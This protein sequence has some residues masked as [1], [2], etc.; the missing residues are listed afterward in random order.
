MRVYVPYYPSHAGHWIYRGYQKAWEHLGYDVKLIKAFHEKSE[1]GKLEYVTTNFHGLDAAPGDYIVQ[2]IGSLINGPGA[3]EAIQNSYKSFISVQPN[4]YPNPWGTH[5]NFQCHAPSEAIR[6]LNRTPNVHLWTFGDE[7][8]YHVRWKKVHTVPLAFDHISYQ[9]KEIERYKKFDVCFVGGWANNGFNEK[10]EIMLNTFKEFKKSNLN[11]GI[12]I[13]KNL[14]HEQEQG[15]LYNS[16]IALNIHDAYQRKLGH[17]TNE[18][19]F[20]SLGLNGILISDTVGQFNRIFS[21]MS[22]SNDPK[23]MVEMCNAVLSLSEKEREG[24]RAHN[25]N[26]IMERECYIHRVQQMLELPEVAPEPIGAD[27][28]IL[29]V[30]NEHQVEEINKLIENS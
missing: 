4:V 14:T 30:M 22:T 9:P 8:R 27:E 17:D 3:L 5:P 6:A 24:I 13:N 12:F 21:D 11:C 18:R 19:T 28:Q 2:F 26:R 23:E 15:L 16:K 29:A 20:K 10:R 1:D 7:T 25:K